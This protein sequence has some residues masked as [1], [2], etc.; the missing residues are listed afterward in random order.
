[1][2]RNSQLSI[3][4]LAIALLAVLVAVAAQS[5]TSIAN[6][7]PELVLVGSSRI[8]DHYTAV[9]RN[10]SG[11]EIRVSGRSGSTASINGHSDY[12]IV[13]FAS[14]RISIRL[15]E[16]VRCHSFPDYGVLCD[17]QNLMTLAL[18]ANAINRLYH[19]VKPQQG[20]T[21][22]ANDMQ[23]VPAAQGS[24]LQTLQ[25]EAD[26]AGTRAEIPSGMTLIETPSGF[27]LVPE[28]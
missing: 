24:F 27:R 10:R 8:G 11:H 22:S 25:E 14:R 28:D 21:I 6:E 26:E 3:S 20:M 4:L 1:M 16:S 13:E 2:A 7:T 5:N 12:R 19:S 23:D 9:L 17:S 15:P 18:N